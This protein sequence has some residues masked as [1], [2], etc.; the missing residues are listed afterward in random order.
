MLNLLHAFLRW[1]DGYAFRT[2][3]RS[4]RQAGQDIDPSVVFGRRVH[5]HADEGAHLTVGPN[6]IIM[7]DCWIHANT[8]TTLT[9]GSR[10]F[11]SHRVTV[12]GQV[13]IGSDVQIAENTTIVAE[14]HIFDRLDLTIR[15]QGGRAAP[16]TIGNDVWIGAGTVV[17]AGVT[18][19]DQVV[20]GA[21]STV[22][23]DVPPRAVVAGSPARILRMRG[24]SSC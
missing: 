24:E 10:T 18:I 14:N 4:L 16:I 19:G 3:L 7:D 21:N 13:Y 5:L 20:V 6:C 8:C 12:S 1:I 9:I 15:E 2:T 23:H 11:L 17:T 22:T